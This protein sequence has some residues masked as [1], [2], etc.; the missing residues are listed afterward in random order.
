M[1]VCECNV[2]EAQTLSYPTQLALTAILL[3]LNKTRTLVCIAA[4]GGLRY[5]EPRLVWQAVFIGF[6]PPR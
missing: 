3:H 6:P 5:D 4:R 2:V 1:A